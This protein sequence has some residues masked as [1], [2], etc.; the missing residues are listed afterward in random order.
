MTK[1]QK[2]IRAKVGLLEL[3][4]QLGNVS[5][6]CKMPASE[7][8]FSRRVTSACRES[9]FFAVRRTS[10]V[11]S[12]A[13]FSLLRQRSSCHFSEPARERESTS[14]QRSSSAR[15]S[16]ASARERSRS[17][18]ACACSCGHAPARTETASRAPRALAL[19]R[20]ATKSRRRPRSAP[21]LPQNLRR[22]LAM[23]STT[24]ACRIRVTSPQLLHVVVQMMAA[25]ISAPS[26]YERTIT[27]QLSAGAGELQLSISCAQ[28]Q[29]LR[30]VHRPD[31][32][33]KTSRST[34]NSPI[35]A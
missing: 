5:Q 19:T 35:F 27:L 17:A 25:P 24:S 26:P 30:P 15:A 2:I 14:A 10:F 20:R 18:R 12:T 33:D 21:S 31:S 9:A 3:A 6:A 13:A 22:E 23:R 11:S 32:R 34:V 16:A 8:S 1:D 28:R 7:S 4:K 29:P